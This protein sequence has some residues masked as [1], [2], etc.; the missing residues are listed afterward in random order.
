MDQN[1]K[2]HRGKKAE[3][4]SPTTLVRWHGDQLDGLP[5][6]IAYRSFLEPAARDLREAADLSQ[7][8]AFANFLRLR[9]YALLSD[10]YFKSD[11]AW[12]QLK[13]P[14]VDI[15]FAPYETYADTLL[16]VKA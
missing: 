15:I 12:M 5:Y 13:E 2:D 9:A 4:Y 3:I 16:G 6:H 14:K 8:A 11:I 7:D 10:D 1:V